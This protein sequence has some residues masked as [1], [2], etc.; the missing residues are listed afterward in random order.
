MPTK[1]AVPVREGQEVWET[2]TDG[3]VWI[4]TVDARNR[5]R[6]VRV[7]ESAGSRLLISTLDREVAQDRVRPD[8]TDPFRN[9]MLRR[10]DVDQNLDENTR[11]EHALSTDQ[12]TAIFGRS[13]TAFRS[14]VDKLSEFNVRR[15]NDLAEPMDASASQTTYLREKVLSYR[16][17]VDEDSF[18]DLTGR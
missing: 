6:L 11:S 10:V 18:R 2:T 12:L 5:E 17:V 7:G 15:L 16:P 8:G 3:V 4:P 14:A 13:G 9:G 1:S